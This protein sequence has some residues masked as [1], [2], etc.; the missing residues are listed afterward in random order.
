MPNSVAP[1]VPGLA[2]PDGSQDVATLMSDRA[3]GLNTGRLD[4][5]NRVPCPAPTRTQHRAGWMAS[6]ATGQHAASGYVVT[7][8]VTGSSRF[9]SAGVTHGV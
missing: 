7:R 1:A 2:I 8:S 5:L 9:R 6:A 4:G 3:R